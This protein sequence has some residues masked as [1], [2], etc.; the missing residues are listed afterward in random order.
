MSLY[1]DSKVQSPDPGCIS[2][3]VEWHEQHPLLA[4]SSYSQDRGGFVTIY[5][6]L[7]LI[8]YFVYIFMDFSVLSVFQP[9]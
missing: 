5:D 1:F 3:N 9:V 6:E 4:V 7:V 8:C 2:I